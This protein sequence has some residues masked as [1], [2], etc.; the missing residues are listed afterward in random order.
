MI[1]I[2]KQLQQI[3]MNSAQWAPLKRSPVPLR[4]PRYE[5]LQR[6]PT[7][8][9]THQRHPSKLTRSFLG[10]AHRNISELYTCEWL[11]VCYKT[12]LNQLPSLE[13]LLLTSFINV[14]Y[15]FPFAI[16]YTRIIIKSIALKI[17]SPEQPPL[18]LEKPA[19]W[20]NP[21]ARL[22]LSSGQARS[23]HTWQLTETLKSQNNIFDKKIYLR[24]KLYL[25]Y[26]VFTLLA[27]QC[28]CTN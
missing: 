4:M 15:W 16:L 26:T 8:A 9:P 1:K 7:P 10:M 5:H 3:V 20:T 19:S 24:Y 27:M 6:P 11:P 18:H 28:C 21:K 12:S 17:L 2:R 25:V 22:I 23:T 13:H 14:I